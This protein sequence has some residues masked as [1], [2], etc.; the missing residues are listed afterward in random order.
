MGSG[1][2]I[3]GGGHLSHFWFKI[4]INGP[5]QIYKKMCYNNKLMFFDDSKAKPKS[6]T[7][8]KNLIVIIFIVN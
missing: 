5:K 7:S 3:I 6:E 4:R 8:N 2:N 1:R